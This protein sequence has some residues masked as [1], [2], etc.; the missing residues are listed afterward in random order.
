M[1]RSVLL[2]ATTALSVLLACGAALAA[3]ISC[4]NRAGDLC[5][6][7]A[8]GDL[9]TGGT[10]RDDIRGVG[11]ADTLR[12]LGSVDTL[13]GGSGA[14]L[15]RGG[16]DPDA[17]NGGTGNDT[18]EGQA[19]SF[20]RYN[21]DTDGWGHDTINDDNIDGFNGNQLWFKNTT[22]A[23]TINL[24]SSPSRPEVANADRTG[25]INWRG[26]TITVVSVNSPS[27]DTIFGNAGFNGITSRGG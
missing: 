22:K 2:L 10:L 7:T 24:V 26:P 5:V 9:M 23:L 11:G 20:D 3:N 13:I 6:G 18:L 1:Q 27:D 25:T 4:P 19:D 21:Y 17:L 15:L 12:G 16:D 8:Q 14:D